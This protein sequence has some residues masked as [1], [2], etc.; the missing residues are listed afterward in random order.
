MLQESVNYI[1][2]WNRG[3]DVGTALLYV[4]SRRLSQHV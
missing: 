2:P 4:V 1:L 3:V